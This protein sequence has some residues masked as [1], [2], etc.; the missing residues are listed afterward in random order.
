M[1]NVLKLI[2]KPIVMWVGKTAFK[3]MFNFIDKNKDGYI[4]EVELKQTIKDIEKLL[5]KLK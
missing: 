5:K 1:K 3:L 2:W 4:D